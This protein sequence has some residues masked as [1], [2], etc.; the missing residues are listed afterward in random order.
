MSGLN[1]EHARS[2]MQKAGLDALVLFQPENFSYAIGASGGVATMW[3][4]AG[5][6]IALVSFDPSEAM[7]AIVS[8]LSAPAL[9][10]FAPDVDV[11]E[12]RIW[13]DMVDL[14]SL[15]A[16]ALTPERVT[17]AYREQGLIYP[18]PERF[19]V[20]RVLDLLQSAL[21]EKGLEFVRIGADLEFLPAADFQILKSKL[22]NIE[23]ADGSDVVRRLRAIKSPSEIAYLRQASMLAEAGLKQMIAEVRIG[24][25]VRDLSEAWRSGVKETADASDIRDLTGLWD[26]I[27]IGT[28]PWST[29]GIVE[30]GMIIK[31]D[32]GCLI[33]GY[34]SDGARTY[35]FGKPSLVAG[36]IFHALAHAFEAGLAAIRPGATFGAVHAATLKEMRVAGYAEYH[37]GHFGH[38][39]GA[40]VGSEEW[41]FI[42]AGNTEVIEPGMVLA[43]ET[44]FYAKGVGALMIE[45]Q[46]LIT[47]AGI[48]VMNTLPRTI[49]DLS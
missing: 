42:S 45:D 43:F 4:K 37:R 6:A 13:V 39:V 23:W 15:G 30:D 48:D 28:D 29:A 5:G 14:S 27:A 17:A 46:L 47:E 49:V 36:D 12:H 1:R 7:V 35:S 24:A 8:D 34:S 11:R 25:S 40:S 26:F 38:G 16:G 10:R 19:D 32:V 21:R 18:R 3:R 20:A 9:R 31:A 33:N 44:P 22:P 41:P 2:L